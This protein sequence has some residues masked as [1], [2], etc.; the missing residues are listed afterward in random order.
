M[1]ANPPLWSAPENG[2]RVGASDHAFNS[3]VASTRRRVKAYV[4]RVTRDPDDAADLVAET[5]ARA[6]IARDQLLESPNRP[7]AVIA[8]ARA[9]G[10]QWVAAHRRI[11]P[12]DG[13]TNS[14]DARFR[15]DGPRAA[16]RELRVARRNWM[17][18]VLARLSEDQ[19]L[20]VRLH[21]LYGFEYELL[22]QVLDLNEAAV[23]ARVHR[24]LVR[25]RQVVAGD[26]FPTDADVRSNQVRGTPG[27]SG[28]TPDVEGPVVRKLATEFPS[29]A[30]QKR[31]QLFS[32]R[33]ATKRRRPQGADATKG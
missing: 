14:A 31:P 1:L 10:R 12:A 8:V 27:R 25:L 3:L 30:S 23:R 6:W 19:R 29:G 18:R 5:Y 21:V 16:T 24:G 20:A 4:R 13:D 32:N 15:A 9:V 28:C 22:A 11:V 17:G 2:G 7:E 26:P 33:E